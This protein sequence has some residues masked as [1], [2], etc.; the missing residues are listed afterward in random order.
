[1]IMTEKSNKTTEVDWETIAKSLAGDLVDL[2]ESAR[3]ILANCSLRFNVI[4]EAKLLEAVTREIISTYKK[5]NS[6]DNNQEEKEDK[7]ED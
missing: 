7:K 2:A 3:L 4:D 1:M 5:E 6:N